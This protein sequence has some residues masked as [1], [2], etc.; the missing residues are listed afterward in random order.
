MISA[1]IPMSSY[2]GLAMSYV[3]P[4]GFLRESD[5]V[6][7][8]SYDFLSN[9]YDAIND[10]DEFLNGAHDFMCFLRLPM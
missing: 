10:S 9:A 8:D 3:A 6:I 7:N 4:M 2:M 1:I 5:N